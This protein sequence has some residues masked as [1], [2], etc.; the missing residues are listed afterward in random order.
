MISLPRSGPPPRGGGCLSPERDR[1]I[2]THI[3]YNLIPLSL[4]HTVSPH[5]IL[6]LNA[7]AFHQSH[8][9]IKVVRYSQHLPEILYAKYKCCHYYLR[10]PEILYAIYK[11][12]HYS[13]QSRLFCTIHTH[14]F[15]IT[16]FFCRSL[17]LFAASC[18]IACI[19]YKWAVSFNLPYVTFHIMG[20]M[21]SVHI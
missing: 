15:A 19:T 14:T 4:Y 1:C 7:N 5:F 9:Y 3:N 20:S 16:R 2:C 17:R 18:Y 21:Y 6:C 8:L 13:V 12:R 10:L 11:C